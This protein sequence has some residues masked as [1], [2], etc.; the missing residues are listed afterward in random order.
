MS[1]FN[2][3]D[4]EGEI[5]VVPGS[6]RVLR[7]DVT[8]AHAGMRLDK[9]LSD[10][11][12]DVSRSRV[13]GLIVEGYALLN[14]V[15]CDSASRKVGE[16][17]RVELVIP[18]AVEAVPQPENIPLDIIYEDEDL[19]VLNKQV[20]LV[21]H[22][23]AGNY[24][25]TLVNAL[26]YHCA[27]ELSGIGGVMR[28]G[29]VHRLD[30]DTSGLMVAAK[31]D[32]AHRGLSAQL[33]DRSLSRIYEALVLKVPV[34]LKGTIDRSIGRDPRNRLRMAISGQ[35]AR[36]ARTHYHVRE[37][38]GGALARVDCKLE[39]GRTHQ[40]RVHMASIKHPLIG[41]SLYG[42]Q[43]TAIAGAMK[44]AGYSAEAIA[45]CTGFER[46]ALH[47]REISFI[48]PADGEEMSFSVGLPEDMSNLLKNIKK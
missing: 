3:N 19:L 37:N 34:P 26:L 41:D 2:E 28:P 31:S 1:G 33:E 22:P 44:S 20:G 14:G 11:C 7:F 5:G 16:G 48:H 6:A 18:D 10:M 30:K 38:F 15:L 9:A 12:F 25:G 35:G 46:Q 39:S 42:P 8:T 47:A 29:I 27:G 23:G 17:D 40:I 21:V 43:V 13:Q 24:T 45:A 32:L 4:P 36:S